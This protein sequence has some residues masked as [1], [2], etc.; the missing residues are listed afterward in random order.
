MQIFNRFTL[1]I[2][3]KFKSSKGATLV[4][5]ALVTGILVVVFAAVAISLNAKRV[6]RT[7]QSLGV[8]KDPAPCP[9]GTPSNECL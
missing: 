8:V 9:P 2:A 7:D 1:F 5:Y 6:S 3:S 4:E